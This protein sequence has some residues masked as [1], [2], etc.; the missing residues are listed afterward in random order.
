MTKN[1]YILVLS[2]LLLVSVK[3]EASPTITFFFKPFVDDM[4]K[5][6][7]KIKKPGHL[8]KAKVRGI[9]DHIPVAGLLVTYGGYIDSSNYNGEIAFPRKHQ[10]SDITI[11]VTTE[12]AP[13]PLFENTILHWNLIPG[14]AAAMYSCRQTYNERKEEYS[15]NMEKVALPADNKIPLSAIVIIAK[16]KNIMINEG[17]TVTNATANLVLPDVYVRKGINIIENNMY[18]LTIRHL[19]KPVEEE[20]RPEPFRMLTHVI[21]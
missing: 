5:V 8:A 12:M 9:I 21:E 11:V 3:I 17:M 2:V 7:Q 16:P 18:M 15:W 13:V 6:T 19:F 1:Y 20:E 10:S 14:T 4:D